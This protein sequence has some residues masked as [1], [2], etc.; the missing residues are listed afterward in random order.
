MNVTIP[1]DIRGVSS[2]SILEVTWSEGHVGRYGYKDL[3]LS[4]G[5]A[6]CVDEMTGRRI[7]QPEMV[8]DDVSISAIEPVGNYAIKITWSDGHDTGIYS[9][10][11]LGEICPCP[12]CSGQTLGPDQI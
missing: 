6:H 11:L 12:E 3:R 9:W 7:I 5:C 2:E 10:K 8:A 1:Q 4:C